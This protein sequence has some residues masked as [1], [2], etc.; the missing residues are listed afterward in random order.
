[1]YQYN[2][3]TGLTSG[4]KSP[5]TS[6]ALAAGNTNPQGIADPPAPTS[7]QTDRTATSASPM[8]V[9]TDFAVAR[10]FDL[11]TRWEPS[12]TFEYDRTESTQ[13]PTQS[14][15]TYRLAEL[16][17]QP[18]KQLAA[19]ENRGA[20]LANRLARSTDDI[21]STWNVDELEM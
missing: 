5:D 19:S 11:F 9:A 7:M 21:F 3:A 1:M 8:A 4:S 18:T 10:L 6:W 16:P 13:L 12:R 14:A 20:S 2:N 17:T 15:P